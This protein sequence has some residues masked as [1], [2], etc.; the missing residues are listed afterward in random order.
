MGTERP[1]VRAT[2]VGEV[3][4]VVV[5][6]SLDR[7]VPSRAAEAQDKDGV[8][9]RPAGEARAAGGGPEVRLVRVRAIG[10]RPARVGTVADRVGTGAAKG[11]TGTVPRNEAPDLRPT[12]SHHPS[13]LV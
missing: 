1:V 12:W 4:R 8:E 5:L 13:S 2:A 3:A 10:V 9:A 11:A 6:V 7:P